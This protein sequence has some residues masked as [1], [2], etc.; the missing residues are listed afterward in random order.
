MEDCIRLELRTELQRLRSNDCVDSF[1]ANA[2]SYF[3]PRTCCV[4][5]KQHDKRE[6]G[7]F[8]EEFICTEMLCLCS[9]T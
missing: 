5:H 2:V 4:E 7:L 9:K 6:L 8:K 3:F 1:T